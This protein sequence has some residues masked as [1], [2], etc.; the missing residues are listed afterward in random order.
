MLWETNSKT[1]NFRLLPSLRP[2]SSTSP[3]LTSASAN[4]GGWGGGPVASPASWCRTEAGS[5][6]PAPRAPRR[7]APG[8]RHPS[9]FRP[10]PRGKGLHSPRDPL[11]PVY[12]LPRLLPAGRGLYEGGGRPAHSRATAAE[13]MSRGPRGAEGRRLGRQG[14]WGPGGS[15][16]RKPG[17]CEKSQGRNYGSAHLRMRLALPGHPPPPSRTASRR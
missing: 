1:L 11:P 10:R 16:S 9:A 3:P 12:I 5:R 8:R 15:L 17:R 2:G 7:P 6:A 14:A 13:L 4:S